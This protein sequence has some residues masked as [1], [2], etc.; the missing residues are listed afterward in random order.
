[1]SVSRLRQVQFTQAGYVTPMLS[2]RHKR[3][4]C[5]VDDRR[6][7]RQFQAVE[8]CPL[9]GRQGRRLGTVVCVRP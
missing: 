3:K 9:A 5:R 7:L 2:R 8:S 4:F 6:G 1:M